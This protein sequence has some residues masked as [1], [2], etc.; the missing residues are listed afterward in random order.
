MGF[1]HKTSNAH[2]HSSTYEAEDTEDSGNVPLT[3]T[4]RVVVVIAHYAAFVMG[5]II[6]WAFLHRID[7]LR[8]RI[9][10]PF[11]L[12]TGLTWL[13]IG[14][15]LEIANHYYEGDWELVGF[16]SDLING[17]FYFFNFGAQYMNALGLRRKGVPFFRSPKKNENTKYC[18]CCFTDLVAMIFDIL[19]VIGI[20]ITGPVYAAMGRDGAISLLSMFGAMAGVGTL[21]RLWKNLGPNRV[22]LFGGIGFLALALL[23]VGMTSV[24]MS[25]G[26]EWVHVFIGGSFVASLIPFTI[27]ILWAE[28]LPEEMET[29]E[30]EEEEMLAKKEEDD[31]E[32]ADTFPSEELSEE[33]KDDA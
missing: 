8:N 20:I 19:M 18:G 28:E 29:S 26:I 1:Y 7:T 15:A 21:F 16:P 25:T 32:A 22:T 10:G 5:T 14:A 4:Q 23:G 2:D 12:L 17:T 24:Y 11:L 6:I 31:L 13:Q 30:E 3:D 9:A 27:A 33:K